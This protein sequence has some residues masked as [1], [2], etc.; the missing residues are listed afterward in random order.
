MKKGDTDEL[1]GIIFDGMAV[2]VGLVG[3]LAYF[4]LVAVT[5]AIVLGG[6]I[7]LFSLL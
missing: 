4:V 3:F 5:F 7:L 2:V 6:A 1:V